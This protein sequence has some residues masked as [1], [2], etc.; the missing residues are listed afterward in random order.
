MITQCAFY[1]KIISSDTESI[2]LYCLKKSKAIVII[3]INSLIR[4]P[5]IGGCRFIAYNSIDDAMCDAISLSRAMTLKSAFYDLS[6]G[7]A[8]AVIIDNNYTIMQ[9][10]II[11]EEFAAVVNALE[12]KYITSFDSGLSH[13]DIAIIKRNTQYVLGHGASNHYTNDPSYY[14]ALG[15]KYAI[16]AAAKAKFHSTRLGDLTIGIC[17]IGNVGTYLLK[18]LKDNSKKIYISDTNA[19]NL[20]IASHIKNV[21]VSCYRDFIYGKYDILAHCGTGPV[22]SLDNANKIQAKIICGATNNQLTSNAVNNIFLEKNIL[23]I[24]DFVANGGGL[25]YA[26]S[27]YAND[28]THITAKVKNIGNK[29]ATLL[30]MNSISLLEEA[31]NYAV[32]ATQ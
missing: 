17:G 23:Y 4:G 28:T 7:G 10:K 30:S 13:E 14:T 8:K 2:Q 26:A 32:Q 20:E 24:P 5:A 12:G 3:A 1:D 19:K 25:I 11:L 18:M 21:E 27:E 6:H 31:Y 22:F 29:V 15:I 9:K 16:E